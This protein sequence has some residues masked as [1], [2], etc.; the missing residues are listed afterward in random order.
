MDTITHLIIGG[1]IAGT[2]AAETIRKRDPDSRIVIISDEPHHLYSRILL[3]KPNFFLGE[4]PFDRVWMKD[5]AWYDE[6][7]I[8]FMGGRTAH[9]LD[10]T[11]KMVTLDD[12]TELHYNKLLIAIGGCVRRW[13]GS[14]E[15]LEGI[16]YLRT[17]DDAKAIIAAV[18]NAKH[19]VVVGGGFVG[20]E[21][22]D[23]LRRSG[24]E[25]TFV[26]REAYPWSKL[27]D[28]TSGAM[29]TK[30]LVDGGVRVVQ[31]AEVA[32][33]VGESAVQGVR[34]TTGEE[35]AAEMVIVGI[36][37]TC[38]FAWIEAA[39][40]AVGRSVMTNE[41]LETSAPDVWAAGDAA[42]FVDVV[43]GDRVQ[44][45][46]WPNAQLHGAVAGKNMTGAHEAYRWVSYY[47]AHGFGLQINFAGDIRLDDQRV[48]VPRGDAENGYGRI[49]LRSGKLVGATLLNRPTELGTITK[50]IDAGIDCL[51]REAELADPT[52]DLASLLT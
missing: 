37:C 11:T 5:A 32:S 14:G 28:S 44:L 25:V 22:C 15:T 9:K 33:M 46:S 39:G 20:F 7:H 48:V 13:K 19:A 38:P 1:G 2:T 50:I 35:A 21:M 12:K 41:F 52:F 36:G 42:E 6:Q 18:P 3:S 47:V 45:G 8:E 30:A 27:L 24:M 29:L 26:I 23:M 10:T 49:I 17:L 40:I 51:G 31:N 34:L 4:V 43:S 16:H